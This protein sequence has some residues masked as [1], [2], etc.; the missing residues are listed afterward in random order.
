MSPRLRNA[1]KAIIIRDGYLLTTKNQSA[2]DGSIFHLL[3]GGGQ[4]PGETLIETV[5]RECWEELGGQIEVGPLAFVRE[6]IGANH[7]F[8]EFDSHAH[9]IDFMFTCTLLTDAQELIATAPDIYQIGIE[10]LPIDA[11]DETMLYPQALKPLLT[12][13]NGRQM[14]VYLGDVN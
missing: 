3:P 8:A 11:L 7:E 14:P 1:A 10:W 9:G 13:L 5:R 4:E 2:V 12:D 6:Y